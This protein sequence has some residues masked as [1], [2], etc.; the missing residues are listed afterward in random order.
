MR[1]WIWLVSFARV[2][3]DD[4][5]F[6][7]RTMRRAPRFF[8][9]LV[10][11]A[12]VGV[13]ATTAMASLVQA[14]LLRQPP[15]ADA[16]RLV[17]LW[18]TLLD[19]DRVYS[20]LPDAFDWK[21]QSQSFE[22]VAVLHDWAFGLNVPGAAPGMTIGALVSG[23]YFPLLGIKPMLGRLL[24]PEDDEVD[25]PC[26]AVLS[27]TLFRTSY[28]SKASLVGHGIEL[29]G[30]PCTLV[31]VAE[32]GFNFA[33]PQYSPVQLWVNISTIWPQY[34]EKARTARDEQEFVVLGKLRPG[35]SVANSN[36]ELAAITERIT[37]E[38]PGHRLG[39]R[40][41][42]LQDD[43]VAPVRP[44]VWGLFAA[45]AT[46]FLAAC[47][48]IA[49]LFLVR[50]QA[51]RGELALRSALGATRSRLARQL[52]TEMALV[53][54]VA[55][56]AAWFLAH[57]FVAIFTTIA[58]S[59]SRAPPVAVD[60]PVLLSGALLSSATGLLFGLVPALA[61]SRVS[62]GSE[63]V[64]AGTGAPGHSHQRH[65]RAALVVAQI[66]VACAL[67]T[68]SGTAL[69]AV[70][71]LM[72][73][74]GGFETEGLI[75]LR[76]SPQRRL[77]ADP[78][79]L[80]LFERLSDQLRSRPGVRS[81]TIC[82]GVPLRSQ[83]FDANF[84]RARMEPGPPQPASRF[85]ANV[86]APGFFDV[87]GIPLLEGRDFIPAD[88][89]PNAK[90]VVVIN[91]TLRA[92]FFPNEDPIGKI[93]EHDFQGNTA[94]AEVI[95]VIGDVR[96]F[97]LQLAPLSEIYM[98]FGQYFI[99]AM[100]LILR[101]EPQQAS[102]TAK[103]LPSWIAETEPELPLWTPHVLAGFERTVQPEQRLSSLLGA[104]AIACLALA[105]LGL[106]SAVSYAAAQRT[107]EFGIRVALGASPSNI[108]WLVSAAAL[109][110]VAYGLALALCAVLTLGGLLS[111]Q[112]AGAAAFD[113]RSFLLAAA[114]VALVALAA[115]IGPALRAIRLSPA[116]ALRR[117]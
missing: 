43:A 18:S 115:C 71:E 100:E 52:L 111:R 10:L 98:P 64:E 8:A 15:F 13:G 6:A 73:T 22:R 112:I 90:R 30:N 96:R 79:L 44:R 45:I 72:R 92:R 114:V 94:P 34:W 24:G 66:A 20:S 51:R 42:T 27:E 108:V 31:G 102:E 2:A 29:D 14:T 106:Y 61:L 12:S 55:A 70:A 26:S 65:W 47:S 4:T 91:E 76:I 104:F 69:R 60:S 105:A 63:L 74:P 88:T 50:T 39:A 1:L 48:N 28:G 87:L 101:V 56:P 68:I 95:G 46:V 7:L 33:F 19:D 84:K 75:T 81:V 53:F 17:M 32:P 37:H 16:E 110:W 5:R 3:R 117:E 77:Y 78:A 35:V 23:E 93:I 113:L 86:V 36:A 49:G 99:R 21:R 89:Q 67:A 107:R 116:N 9:A 58:A 25:A 40:S 38:H 80:Q 103:L 57:W 59:A 97:G 83:W 62:I 11:I 85:I 82:T 109:R 54:A 41:T